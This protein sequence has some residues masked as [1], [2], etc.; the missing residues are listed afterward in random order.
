LACLVGSA[1]KAFLAITGVD[2]LT[3]TIFFL[4]PLAPG[5]DTILAKL[6]LPVFRTAISLLNAGNAF[7]VFAMG[8]GIIASTFL[9]TADIAIAGV[10]FAPAWAL[11]VVGVAVASHRTLQIDV[12]GFAVGTAVFEEGAAGWQPLRKKSGCGDTQL[13]RQEPD[14]GQTVGQEFTMEDDGALICREGDVAAQILGRVTRSLT[15]FEGVEHLLAG[16]LG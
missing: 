10:P 8:P 3:R 13:G 15:H 11:V 16:R 12:T 5:S 1:E 6:T 14:L 2:D 7:A 9:F 4:W